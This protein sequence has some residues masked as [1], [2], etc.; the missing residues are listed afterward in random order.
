MLVNKNMDGTFSEVVLDMDVAVLLHELTL[1]KR[2][3]VVRPAHR[4]HFAL[5]HAR[6]DTLLLLQTILRGRL[7]LDQQSFTITK[8]LQVVA[9]MMRTLH[10]L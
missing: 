10:S 3:H 4:V 5:H 9:R 2:C 7:R 6:L 1:L 8:Y